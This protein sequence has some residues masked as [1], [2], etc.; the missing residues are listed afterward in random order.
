MRRCIY[1]L[2]LMLLALPVGA[3]KKKVAMP[4]VSVTNLTVENLKRPL[5]IDTAEPRFSWQITSDQQDVRQTAYQIVVCDDHGEVWNSGK[6]DSDQQ[7]WLPYAGKRLQS[8]TTCTWKVKVWTTAGESAWSSD[9]RFSV[10][11]LHEGKWSGYWIGLERLMPG[12]ER[13]F[14]TRMAA[15]YLRKEFSLKDKPVKRATAYVAGIGLHVFYVNGQ[16]MGDGVLQPVPSDYRKTIYYNTYDVTSHFLH[17]TPNICLGI[18]LGNGRLFPMQQHKPYKIHSFGYPKCRIN[19]IVE[20]TDGTTQRLQTDDKGW[21]VTAD[22]PIRANNE[23][24]GEEYDAR[25][26]MRGWSEVGFD[27]SKWMKAERTDIPQA[28]LR[29]QMTPGMKVLQQIN[30]QS[31]NGRIV[32]VG[33]NIAGWLKVRVRGQKGDTIRIVYAEKLNNDGSLYRE[34]FRNARSTDIYVCN[35]EEGKEGRWWTPAFVYHG[36]KYAEVIGLKDC[37]KDDFVAEVVADEMSSTGQFECSD[38]VLTQLMRNAWWGVLDNYKGMPVDCP[39]R[40]E[41]QPW[42]G[43]RTVGSLG[44][45]FLFNNERLYTKWMRDICE[46]QRTDGCVPDV[47]PAFWNYYSDDVAWAAALPFTCDML[48]RQYGNKQPIMDSYPYVK[49]W[50]QHIIE[51]YSKDGIIHCGKYADWCVPPESLELIHSADPS[52]KTDVTLISTAYIIR[53][54]QLMEQWGC[55]ADYWRPLREQMITA[56]NKQF[57]TVKKGT[58]PAP[59]HV[60]YPDSVFY[61]NNTATANLLALSFG[62]VP[63]EYR[64]EVMKNVVENIIIKNNAHVPCGVIGI[65]WLLRGLSD[66]GF[67]DIA[68]MIATQKS[69][70][71]WGYMAENGATTIWE[72]WNGNTASPKMNSGNHVML[73]GD[74]LTWC[75]QYVGGIRQKDNAYKHIV[76]K[77]TFSIQDCSWANVSYDSP[78]GTV[79]SHWKKTLQHVEWD[80]TIPCNTIAD[81]CLP[82]GTVRQVGSGKYHFSCDIPTASSAIT[83]DEF[84]YEQAPFPQCH[85]ATI[86]ETK[87]GDLVATYFGGKHERH[88]DVCIWV[89]IK[90]KGQQ[91]WSK[92][93]LAADG[94]FTLGTAYAEIAGIT[95]ESTPA[96]EG[97]AC[98]GRTSAHQ[99]RKACWNP[100]I[101]EMPNGELW[102]FFKVGLKVS[103]WSGW[104]CKSKDGG[105]TWSDKEPLPKGFLGPIKNKPEIIDGRLLCPSSTEDNGWKFHMEIY[106]IARKEWKYVGPVKAELAMRTEDMKAPVT[107]SEKEDIEAPDAGGKATEDGRH[108]IDCIQPS[109]LKLKDGRLQVLM[110]TRNGKIATSFSSDN[111]DTWSNVTLLDVPNNQSGTDAVTLQDGR[112]VLIYNDFATLPGTKKGVR[113]PLSIAISSD[114]THWHHALTLEDSPISQYSYPSIIQGKDG[115]LHA[116]YTWRRLRVAYKEI[117][118]N[119][120]K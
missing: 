104:L 9:E 116:V 33:Q 26:E 45:S 59:G 38:P 8:N 83:K 119:K 85:A 3:A 115:K 55:E 79:T 52:R 95:T 16:R 30:P 24:D 112:H 120:L 113:T 7:L 27:D 48:W 73:L 105:R 118:L 36:F 10:G 108:P 32:D 67:S 66:N 18:V 62:I 106:D 20:Y 78:Y 69:Y 99:R 68:Y 109:I 64:V 107:K 84:L 23:Y 44:E 57:L 96:S 90:K 5:G 98:Q 89:S 94:V 31:L 117:D 70:P 71:S 46:A 97:P 19:V 100:V 103:D 34:N 111:G 102:L 51:E 1:G 49:K 13:G 81:V 91:E 86:V 25:M 2:L 14:H 63:E 77:P 76:L 43:D 93:I 80:V 50:V 6:V 42:L 22:G 35:G 92:P 60:L 101:T 61:A 28:Y 88:P 75:Y 74:L 12:E 72:L 82:D 56:F 37:H 41:R 87:K 53:T 17:H 114:G 65:S 58:S 47:A 39:Q 15:R 40:D 29:S 4:G 54:M 21:K 110:R 11:L